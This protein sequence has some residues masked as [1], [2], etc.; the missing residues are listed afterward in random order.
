MAIAP[1]HKQKRGGNAHAREP[2]M[3]RLELPGMAWPPRCWSALVQL[4]A[5]VLEVA[6]STHV[7]QTSS[8]KLTSDL[9]HAWM[10][11]L[12]HPR[13]G[14]TSRYDGKF[15]FLLTSRGRAGQNDVAKCNFSKARMLLEEPSLVNALVE[16]SFLWIELGRVVRKSK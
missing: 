6:R 16:S 14:R 13:G 15:K 10:W 12:P 7:E 8:R 9:W 2:S 3:L 11:L 4:D 5:C 1:P